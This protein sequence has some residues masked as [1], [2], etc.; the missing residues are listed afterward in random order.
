MLETRTVKITKKHYKSSV[1][2]Q[3]R[4]ENAMKDAFP[5]FDLIMPETDCDEWSLYGKAKGRKVLLG[6]LEKIDYDLD[7]VSSRINEKHRNIKTKIKFPLKYTFK[8]NNPLNEETRLFSELEEIEISVPRSCYYLLIPED[9]LLSSVWKSIKESVKQK[10]KKGQ[11]YAIKK[12]S[13]FYDGFK[14]SSGHV[15]FL[16]RIYDKEKSQELKVVAKTEKTFE[17][18]EKD[19]ENK[20]N[21][22]VTFKIK[23][24]KDCLI[25]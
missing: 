18:F 23:L 5:D 16:I 10:M 8:F 25:H 14:D 15:Q 3:F 22:H 13:C 12:D 11:G 1:N 6:D 4:L 24:P 9:T 19:F 20:E 7:K 17:Q 21:R 2:N